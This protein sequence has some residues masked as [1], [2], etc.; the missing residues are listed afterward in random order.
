MELLLA[1]HNAHKAREFHEL[2]GQNFDVLDLS[3]FPGIVLP[4]E[5][6]RTF[7]ENAV[8][9]AIAASQHRPVQDR[10][11]LVLADD[12]G[13][14]VNALGG[15]PGIFSARYA[16]ENATDQENVSKLL[17]ELSLKRDRAARFRCTLALVREGKLT[18]TFEGVVDGAIVDLPRG[19]AGFGYDPVFVPDGFDKTFAE[20]SPE[21]KN[22]ISHR[23]R[24]VRKL[25]AALQAGETT[26]GFG[27]GGG[28][29]GGA[30]G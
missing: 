16:G 23:A 5:A 12:S 22:Q 30:P 11:L 18:K 29:P 4:K 1:T 7:E 25:R 9:K 6:G 8:L 24:A 15:E 3:A 27:G 26:Q 14:E 13:L 20:L 21:L 2:L 17:R 19:F 10:H 28:A